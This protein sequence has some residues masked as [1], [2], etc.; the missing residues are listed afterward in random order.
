MARTDKWKVKSWYSVIAP[1]VFDEKRVGDVLASDDAGLTD[2]LIVV[3]LSDLTGE[4]PHSYTRVNLRVSEVKGKTVYT[5]LVGHELIRSYLRTLAR[6]RMS[7]VD[8][9][10]K[11]KTKD[12]VDVSVKSAIVTANKISNATRVS[13]RKIAEQVIIER[14]AALNFD[15]FMQEVMFKKLSAQVYPKLREVVPVKR[16]EVIKT[17]VVKKKASKAA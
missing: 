1:K 2:R 8:D 11:V 15:E 16:F 9:V 4:I 5:K 17:E 3:N 12:D 7:L 6:R 14:A 13:L 10:V